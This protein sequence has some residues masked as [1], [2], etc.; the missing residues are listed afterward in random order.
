[1]KILNFASANIDYVYDVPHILRPG[2]TLAARSMDIFPGGKGLNQ[3]VAA[4]KAGGCVYHA[5]FIGSDGDFLVDILERSGAKLPYLQRV[6][7]KNGHAMIQVNSQG[8]NCIVIFQ[9][10]NG[11]FTEAYI[12]RV[13]EDFEKGDYVLAQNEITY[14]PYILDKAAGKGL[15]VVLNPSPYTEELRAL[16]LG[17]I[18]W[19]ILNETEAQAFFHTEDPQQ[20]RSALKQWT[21]LKVVLTLGVRGSVCI[22]QNTILC[23]PA[24]RV[25]AVDTTAA[26][27]CFTGY[28]VA[29][30]ARGVGCGTALKTASCA[31]AV[32]VS[33]RGAAPSI[34]FKE[35]VEAAL[36]SLEAYPPE[37]G[38]KML[39]RQ[40]VVEWLET[41]LA[42]ANLETLAGK[43][44]YSKSYTGSLV[45]E[46]FGETFSSILQKARCDAAAKL[47]RTTDLPIKEIAGKVGYENESFFRRLFRER[48]GK[49]P[50]EYRSEE[51]L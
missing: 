39:L 45:R 40:T 22:T 17:K 4:A 42:Q 1:M 47:L 10:T 25:E 35:E 51:A 37:G 23:C 43:L 33:R 31:S 14:L 32:T 46:V 50:Q 12:D 44:G 8:E 26:G 16:D 5:G 9:G 7:E 34:P 21:G 24:Y 13:L 38:K 49:N 41:D 2:E 27:D 48:Y 19:L 20:I 6:P 3:S 11:L 18:S 29:Q 28:F 30:L 15:E 36:A